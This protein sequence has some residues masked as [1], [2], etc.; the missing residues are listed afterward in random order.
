[1]NMLTQQLSKF[2]NKFSVRIT[3]TLLRE[4]LS[5]LSNNVMLTLIFGIYYLFT[6]YRQV[7]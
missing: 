5:D 4:K 6:I 2:C 3:V 7:I 1:M